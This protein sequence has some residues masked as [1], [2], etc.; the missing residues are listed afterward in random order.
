[1]YEFHDTQPRD[2]PSNDSLPI[3]A[4]TID[5]VTIE[6]LIPEY[7][8]LKVMGRELL[9]N[10]LTKLKV[11]SQ[12]G[13][14]LQKRSRPVRTITVRYQVTAASPQRFREIY[15]QLNEILNG[16][17]KKISFADDPDKYFIGTLSDVDTPEGGKLSVVSSFTFTCF[18]PYAY[19]AKEDKFTFSDRLTSKQIDFSF[20]DKVA[21]KTSPVAHAIY[22][23]FTT[24]DGASQNPSYYKQ[25]LTQLEYSRLNANDGALVSSDVLNN[26]ESRLDNFK[27]T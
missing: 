1:M 16:E 23:G 18:D 2:M 12:D 7:R 9:G 8:T 27:T 20:K 26:F 13:E 4:M 19:A 15:Y 25:E 5:G 24:G 6:Q 3:E 21:G 22:K 17:N 14:R 10:T 11:G